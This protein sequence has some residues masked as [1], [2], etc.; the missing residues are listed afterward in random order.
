MREWSRQFDA[1]GRGDAEDSNIEHAHSH[2]DD[3]TVH[4]GERA[5]RRP[6]QIYRPF[7]VILNGCPCRRRAIPLAPA[8][9]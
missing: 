5:V 1:Y 2:V 8:A 6:I 4:P 7:V 9:E 3:V